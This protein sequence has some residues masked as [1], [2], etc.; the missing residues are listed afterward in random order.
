MLWTS[1][2]IQAYILHSSASFVFCV[3]A[4]ILVALIAR[5]L[6]Q[7][8]GLHVDVAAERAAHNAG[9]AMLTLFTFLLALALND[10]RT[11]FDRVQSHARREAQ[12]ARQIDSELQVLGAGGDAEAGSAYKKAIPRYITIVS[13]SERESLVS[14]QFMLHEEATAILGQIRGIAIRLASGAVGQRLLADVVL[15]EECRQERLIDAQSETSALFW[16]A[17]AL[18]FFV[19]ILLF[20]SGAFGRNGFTVSLLLAMAV[21][22]VVGITVEFE[23]PY[24]GI[25]RVLPLDSFYSP[26]VR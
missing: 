8:L 23:N 11:N 10:A 26:G 14:Q 5:P 7:I 18:L 3:L 4:A 9:V 21:G 15:L 24:E 19:A 2:M 25:V 13:T 1:P 16:I 12:L 17:A 6:K 22:V 20:D